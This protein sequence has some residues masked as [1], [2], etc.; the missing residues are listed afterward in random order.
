MQKARALKTRT[1]VELQEEVEKE[2]RKGRGK[3][4]R[5][6]ISSGDKNKTD[7]S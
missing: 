2:G 1:P 6:S 5:K 7:G 3:S 4:R